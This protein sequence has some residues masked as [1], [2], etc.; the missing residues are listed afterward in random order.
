MVVVFDE[1]HEIFGVFATREEAEAAVAKS[2]PDWWAK[3][4]VYEEMSEEDIEYH[5]PGLLKANGLA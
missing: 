1:G 3:G 5:Y 2:N 4:P